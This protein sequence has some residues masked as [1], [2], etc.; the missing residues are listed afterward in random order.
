MRWVPGLKCFNLIDLMN[1]R[2]GSYRLRATN[3][4][5]HKVTANRIYQLLIDHVDRYFLDHGKFCILVCMNIF[6]LKRFSFQ[7]NTILTGDA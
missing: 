3:M 1:Y 5:F 4:H 2:D 7:K 6:S